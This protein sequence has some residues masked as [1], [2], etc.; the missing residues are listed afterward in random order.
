MKKVLITATVQSHIAQFHGTLIDILHSHGYQVHAAAGNNL[1]EKNG[2]KL[3]SPDMV[4]DIQFDRSPFSAKN[5]TAYRQLK[6]IIDANSYEIIHCNTPMGGVIT[7][8]A[9][10]KARKTGTK[11]FYTAHGFHFYKG[12][13]LKNWLFY[14]PVE[15]WLAR[16]TDAII[17]ITGED[18]LMASKMLAAKVSHIHGVG[19]NPLR[20]FPVSEEEKMYM[21]REMGYPCE[22]CILLCTG[23]LNRNKN[24]TVVIKAFSEVVKSRTDVKLLLAGNGPMEDELKRLAKGLCIE[25]NVD[26]LGYRTDLEKFVQISD[27]IVSASLREGLGLN[28][29]EAMMCGKPVV[30][31]FN[32]GHRELV[33]EGETGFLFNPADTILL[34]GRISLLASDSAMRNTMGM[35]AIQSSMPYRSDTVANEI[36]EIY[37]LNA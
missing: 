1:A 24:Q 11:V 15:K 26:F 29:V 27:V 6:E 17:T 32:R 16:H 23:E 34:A 3:D 19:V 37:G 10:R 12:A 22:T 18:C 33:R 14:Y 36:K 31:S 35:S 9:A 8:L 20:Y 13:P 28:I 30:A 5:I 25:N 21:R 2:L 7:R 4:Y